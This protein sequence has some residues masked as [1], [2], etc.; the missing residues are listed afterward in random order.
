MQLEHT[1]KIKETAENFFKRGHKSRQEGDLEQA[2]IAYYR[3]IELDQKYYY[4]YHHLS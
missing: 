1:E 2:I 4:A 3:A